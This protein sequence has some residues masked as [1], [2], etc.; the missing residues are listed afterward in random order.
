MERIKVKN[1]AGE[2]C[3]IDATDGVVTIETESSNPRTV[4]ITLLDNVEY[5]NANTFAINGYDE[6]D[7]NIMDYSWVLD[8]VIDPNELSK[9]GIKNAKQFIDSSTKEACQNIA[10]AAGI[11]CIGI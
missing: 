11:R 5:L 10:N 3:Y 7:G 6:L 2:L 9:V 4:T 8:L 1:N